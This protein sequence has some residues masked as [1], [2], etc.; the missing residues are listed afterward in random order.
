MAQWQGVEPRARLDQQ[1]GSGQ[2]A[3]VE[4]GEVD[5]EPAAAK[6]G[7]SRVVGDG[8]VHRRDGACADLATDVDSPV[9]GSGRR[10]A[11]RQ[12]RRLRARM[13]GRQQAGCHQRQHKSN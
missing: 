3:Q 2:D 6:N 8:H 10:A 12:F 1:L 5:V 4:V 11:G 13:T 9:G 7:H